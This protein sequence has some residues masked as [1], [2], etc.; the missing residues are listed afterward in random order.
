MHGISLGGVYYGNENKNKKE[1]GLYFKF[2]GVLQYLQLILVN[3]FTPISNVGPL[4]SK[5]PRARLLQ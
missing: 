1:I 2:F 5:N 3:K 4:S